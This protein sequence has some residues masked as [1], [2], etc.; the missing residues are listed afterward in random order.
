MFKENIEQTTKRLNYIVVKNDNV[1]V[2]FY[3]WK[4]AYD[5]FLSNEGKKL[6][7]WAI[8]GL[9]NYYALAMQK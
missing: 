2:K 4:R 5:L 9:D 8:Q 7:L 6:Y 1:K 3:S